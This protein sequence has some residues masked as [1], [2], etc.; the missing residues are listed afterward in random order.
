MGRDSRGDG[1]KEV[2][3]EK[4]ETWRKMQT[5]K[6]RR[7]RRL[8]VIR[9]MSPPDKHL[10]ALRLHSSAASCLHLTIDTPEHTH[11]HTITLVG[12]G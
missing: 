5:Q 6:Q 9:E 1:Y 8:S 11:T 4:M 10:S 2:D 7:E 3:K 12:G